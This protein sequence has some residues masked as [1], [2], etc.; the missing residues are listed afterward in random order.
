[1]TICFNGNDF[2]YETEAVMKLFLPVTNFEFLYE[3][4][5]SEGDDTIRS[6]K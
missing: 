2:K 5:V 6:V 1:M 4:T 3:E